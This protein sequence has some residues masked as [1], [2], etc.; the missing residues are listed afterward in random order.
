MD[1][2]RRLL[3]TTTSDLQ[4]SLELMED[5]GSMVIAAGHELARAYAGS[6]VG[7]ETFT[8]A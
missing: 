7:L 1:D 2:L 5:I 3:M 8:R 4:R 6:R